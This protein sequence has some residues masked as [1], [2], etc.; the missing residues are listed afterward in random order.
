VVTDMHVTFATDN[1]YAPLTAVAAFSLCEAVP[2]T[3]RLRITVLADELESTARGRLACTIRNHPDVALDIVDVADLLAPLE[4][5]PVEGR[6]RAF[7]R[8]IWATLFLAAALPAGLPRTLY[9][10]SDVIVRRDPTRLWQLDLDGNIAAAVASRNGTGDPIGGP[11]G[12]SYH[13]ELGLP[14]DLVPFNSGVLLADLDAWR[15][16]DITSR[17]LEVLRK[18]HDRIVSWDQEVLN[19][20][21]AGRWLPLPSVWNCTDYWRP[22]EDCWPPY[23]QDL[24]HAVIRHFAGYKPWHEGRPV[25]HREEFHRLASRTGTTDGRSWTG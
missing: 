22:V 11:N 2:A 13:A 14:P 4:L 8:S 17:C 25:P 12:I 19:A 9:L 6:F 23:P 5:L 3:T 18:F 1:A 24:Q 16:E 20:V 7:P 10:D 15:R 21:L